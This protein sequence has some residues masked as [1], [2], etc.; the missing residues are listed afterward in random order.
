MKNILNFDRMKKKLYDNSVEL[1]QKSFEKMD[2]YAGLLVEWNQKMNLTAITEPE[3]M[4]NK[5]FIDSL[6]FAKQPEISGKIV[7]VGSGAGFPG[8]VAKIYKPELD[9]TLI[10]PT[11]KRVRFLENL[12]QELGLQVSVVKERAEEA[13]R[14]SWRET[15]DV[16]T[17]RAVAALP[18][19]C[20]YCLPLVKVG[21][22][23]VAMKGSDVMGEVGSSGTA[24]D[25]LGG[26]L[27]KIK[28]FSLPDGSF[29]SL[30]FIKKV[31]LTP[32]VY[33]RNGGTIAK[34]P[35]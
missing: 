21:G 11:G 13:A 32:A 22:F 34:K 10:E 14:K 27:E 3:E 24:I 33:P 23:M 18:V 31:S 7:D 4:E 19:L 28:E 17:A 29:R 16:A 35:L 30:V 5:H 15:F 2:D 8:M 1:S 26:K 12:I 25:K 9:V 20:E 6:L